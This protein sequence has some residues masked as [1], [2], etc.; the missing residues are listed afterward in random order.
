[1]FAECLIHAGH[2]AACLTHIIWLSAQPNSCKGMLRAM[3]FR[4][5][6]SEQVKP[7]RE[8]EGIRIHAKPLTGCLWRLRWVGYNPEQGLCQLRENRGRVIKDPWTSQRAA[9]Q[10]GCQVS[11]RRR[12][13]SL[14]DQLI[15]LVKAED[16]LGGML[17]GPVEDIYADTLSNIWVMTTFIFLLKYEPSLGFHFYSPTWWDTS[18]FTPLLRLR[19]R[20]D[21]CLTTSRPTDWQQACCRDPVQLITSVFGITQAL[22]LFMYISWSLHISKLSRVPRTRDALCPL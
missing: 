22:L 9:V 16:F 10:L 14:L 17:C 20:S 3:F 12:S 13:S 21:R 5:K 2:Q 18:I 8:G 1:M 15:Q 4:W 7:V 19:Y 11:E 6:A